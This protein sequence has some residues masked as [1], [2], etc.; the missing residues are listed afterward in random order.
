MRKVDDSDTKQMFSRTK[1]SIEAKLRYTPVTRRFVKACPTKAVH[2]DIDCFAARRSF[3]S[4]VMTLSRV[5]S[6]L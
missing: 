5:R 2:F 3:R 6:G 1:V 4:L